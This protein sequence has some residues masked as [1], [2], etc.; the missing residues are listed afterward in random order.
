MSDTR[1]GSG[2]LR[3]REPR[4]HQVDEVLTVEPLLRQ[5]AQPLQ[6][7]LEALERV[8][9]ALDVRVVGREEA[10]L[11]PRL[12]DDP[13]DGLVRVGRDADLAPH[14]LARA[15]LEASEALLVLAEGVH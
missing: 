12:P 11:L 4:A 10:D 5:L 2:R 13:A 6:A 8:P 7:L 9:A 1:T 3:A 14:V 15:Q